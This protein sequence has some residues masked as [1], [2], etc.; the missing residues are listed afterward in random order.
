HVSVNADTGRLRIL[1]ATDLGLLDYAY[2]PAGNDPE[3][4]WALRGQLYR[5]ASVRGLRLQTDAKIDESTEVARSVWRLVAEEPKIELAA[6]SD[7]P[8]REVLA[9]LA[10]ARAC[11]IGTE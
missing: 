7:Q 3:G 6:G 10:L 2:A 11:L 4:P 5:W 1:V 8:E 9:V